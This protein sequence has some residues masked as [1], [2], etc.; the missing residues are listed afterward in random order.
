MHHFPVKGDTTLPQQPRNI[1]LT[2]KQIFWSSNN[3]NMGHLILPDLV[4]IN[5]ENLMCI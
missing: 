3:I 1:V 4:T 5:V 2:V